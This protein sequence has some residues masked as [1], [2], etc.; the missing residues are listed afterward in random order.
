MMAYEDV[1]SLMRTGDMLQWH[2][3][4]LMGA[5][6]RLKRRSNIN[7]TSVIVRLNA[8]ETPGYDLV[9]NAEAVGKIVL[10]RLS[11]RLKSHDG[12]CY[13]HALTDEARKILSEED[14]IRRAMKY[15]GIDYD[16]W[17]IMQFLTGRPKMDDNALICSEYVLF[18]YGYN[19]ENEK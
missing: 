2:T 17:A 11:E 16:I 6:I 19:S 4:G 7:H 12:E 1:R 18:V 8:Y 9:M 14:M 13:W 10:N 3:H 5:V 15:M